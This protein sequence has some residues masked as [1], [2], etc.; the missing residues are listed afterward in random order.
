[1]ANEEEAFPE[2]QG[3]D[4][5]ML[6]KLNYIFTR[7]DKIK[8]VFLMAAIIIGSFLELL[9]VSVFSPFIDMIMNPEALEEDELISGIYRLFSFQN[10]E[11]FLA[12]IAV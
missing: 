2:R 12:F 10:Q 3:K 8:I 1:M 7:K 9:A 5:R 6:R 4:G 11:Y